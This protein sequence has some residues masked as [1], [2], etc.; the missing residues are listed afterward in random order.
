MRNYEDCRCFVEYLIAEHRRLHKMLRLASSI[1]TANSQ[2]ESEVSSA[3]MVRVLRQ[4]RDELERHFAQE[5][6]GGCLEEAVSYCPSLSSEARRVEAEHPQLLNSVDRLIAQTLDSDSSV[7]NQ[8]AVK[9]RFDE[10]CSELAAHEA[11]ENL[12]LRQAFGST[13]N[14]SEFDE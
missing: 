6:S 12:L 9:Q 13:V 8:L 1:I 2:I 11:A 3:A 5:E 10:L 14:G 7:A 4:V